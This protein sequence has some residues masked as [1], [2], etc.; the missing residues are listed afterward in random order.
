MK[1]G[2]YDRLELSKGQMTKF[3]SYFIGSNRINTVFQGVV[4]L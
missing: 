4:R 2:V 1:T 3:K